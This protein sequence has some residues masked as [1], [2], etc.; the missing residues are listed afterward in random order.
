[1]KIRYYGDKEEAEVCRAFIVWRGL[2]VEMIEDIH[3]LD[4][5]AGWCSIVEDD[6]GKF[7]ADGIRD[8]VTNWKFC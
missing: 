8:L 4:R 3:V 2:D 7:V 5:G 1:M 6:N